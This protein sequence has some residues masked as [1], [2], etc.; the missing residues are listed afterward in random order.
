MMRRNRDNFGVLL[1]VQH[2]LFTVGLE[3]IPPVTLGTIG[4]QVCLFLGL[5]KVPWR[6]IEECCISAYTLIERREFM[7]I[8]SSALE[9]SDSYHL[10]YNMASFVWK[11]IILESVMG[12]PFFAYL[13]VV[14]TI[15]V[16]L[17]SVSINYA[18]AILFSSFDFMSSCAIGF[19]GVIF[20]LKV[21]VNKVYPDVHPVIGGYNLRVPGG[22]YVWLELALISLFV[23]RASFVGHLAGI[24]VGTAYSVGFL[25]PIFDIFGAVAGYNPHR[26]WTRG[27]QPRSYGYR[28][29]QQPGYNPTY[30]RS[31]A[32]FQVQRFPPILT[33]LLA[34]TLVGVFYHDLL[35]EQLKVLYRYVGG[36]CLNSYLV[37][38][39]HRYASIFTAPLH[40]LNG[41][42][43]LYSV[44]TLLRV[45]SNIERRVGLLR[46]AILVLIL[47][48]GSSLAYVCLVKYVLVRA[49]SVGGVYPYEMKYKCFM[50]PTAILIAMKLA[51]GELLPY[52]NSTFLIFELPAIPLVFVVL[53]E[54][55]LLHMLFPQAWVVGNAA[56]MLAGLVFVTIM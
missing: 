19:S 32:F 22:M 50:G 13:L 18:L 8:F 2:L 44:L 17:V 12:A 37:F 20:A 47:T 1:L 4:L 31:Y 55:F 49:E 41:Y 24:L 25:H 6:S 51:H 53:G 11:G 35:P 9:H 10:Y 26:Q 29:P 43:L 27:A 48:A 15:L 14:F 3:N 28:R 7:R 21:V 45:G 39:A 16:A 36:K 42:H 38:D 33:T 56:G 34:A 40:T 52:L 46:Y 23:P 54:I 30:E 5:I